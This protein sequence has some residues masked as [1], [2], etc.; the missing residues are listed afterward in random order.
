MIARSS[1]HRK[2]QISCHNARFEMIYFMEG[3]NYAVFQIILNQWHRHRGCESISVISDIQTVYLLVRFLISNEPLCSHKSLNLR[4]LSL[5]LNSNLLYPSSADGG[6][7]VSGPCGPAGPGTDKP[8]KP[9][10]HSFSWEDMS[11]RYIYFFRHLRKHTR[12]FLTFRQT[13][14]M[15]FRVLVFPLCHLWTSFVRLSE[16][17]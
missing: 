11:L 1:A 2:R 5:S 8:T 14:G 16:F 6:H 17:T 15:S 10:K 12:P 13:T 4:P 3:S 9:C 7:D